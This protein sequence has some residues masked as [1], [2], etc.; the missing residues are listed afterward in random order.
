[1]FLSHRDAGDMG[2]VLSW[3]SNGEKAFW[4]PAFPLFRNLEEVEFH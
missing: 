3:C 1:M 4:Q 2:C